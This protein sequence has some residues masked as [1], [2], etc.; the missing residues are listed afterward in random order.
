DFRIGGMTLLVTKAIDSH[1][2]KL[3]CCVEVLG[4]IWCSLTSDMQGAFSE[5]IR[6]GLITGQF[7]EPIADYFESFF[8]RLSIGPFIEQIVAFLV[9]LRIQI[10]DIPRWPITLFAANRF[11]LEMFN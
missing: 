1:R 4:N 2:E 7:P 8:R 6:S 5:R 9:N 10:S 3:H 11:R